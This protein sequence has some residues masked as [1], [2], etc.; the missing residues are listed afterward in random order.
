VQVHFVRQLLDVLVVERLDPAG[1]L[2]TDDGDGDEPRDDER[3]GVT[4]V[5][6]GVTDSSLIAGTVS[7]HFDAKASSSSS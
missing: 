4:L 2:P 5:F 3:D 6:I 7:S 1:V